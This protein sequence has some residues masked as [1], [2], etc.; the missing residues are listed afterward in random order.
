MSNENPTKMREI[1]D[2]PKQWI[3]LAVLAT[4][5]LFSSFSLLAISRALIL[6]ALFPMLF[7]PLFLVW[8]TWRH[9]MRAGIMVAGISSCLVFIL[10]QLPTTLLFLTQFA[11]VGLLLGEGLR[12]KA[13][14]MA[15][16]F[17]T[18]LAST[19][20]FLA[21]GVTYLSGS[22]GNPMEIL[23]QGTTTMEQTLEE[24]ARQ[25]PL[26]PEERIYYRQG[27]QNLVAFVRRTFPALIFINAFSIV[28]LNLLLCLRFASRLG[29]DRSHI[30]PFSEISVPFE[31]VWG[32]IVSGMLYL[33]KVPYLKWAGLNVMLIFLLAYLV[34][35]YAILS[36]FL[37]RSRIPGI[38]KG[39]LYLA[40]LLHPALILLLCGAGLF[41]TWFHF[42]KRASA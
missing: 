3:F 12:R 2:T 13:S 42:R 33:L 1:L 20:L 18:S 17:Y 35:G 41:E 19:L 37:N 26:G 8:T 27:V 21:V 29:L 15:L 24:N 36:F 30:P 11:V 6:V 10:F 7:S 23:K 38:V 14:P 16:L 4:T 28:Y 39:L 31:W 25:L 40:F 22:G 34:Q 32:L 5:L 9:G